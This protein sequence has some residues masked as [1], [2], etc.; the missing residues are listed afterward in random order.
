MN[1]HKI[2]KDI[3]VLLNRR[4]NSILNQDYKKVLNKTKKGDFVFLDPPYIEDKNYQFVY[5]NNEKI[6]SDFLA[7]LK[8]QV[9]NLDKKGVLWC[10]SQADTKTIRKL[11]KSYNINTFPVY[12]HQSKSY[13][14]ELL[15]T[16][17]Q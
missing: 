4:G 13:K 3:S 12:R 14:N 5:N 17:Y 1:N 6:D 9:E 2:I 7:T 8:K 15:I 11:F 16:N 10:M